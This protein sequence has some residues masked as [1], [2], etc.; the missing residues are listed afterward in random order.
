ME[1]IEARGFTRSLYNYL[2]EDQYGALQAALVRNPETGDVI[3]GT[4]GFR[5]MRWNDAARGKGRRGGLR[6]IYYYFE[7]DRQIWMM[8]IYSKKEAAD[9]SAAE[10]K[11]LRSLIQHEIEQRRHHRE[12]G[13]S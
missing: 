7:A 4:G 1:L 8:S 12:E 13:K 9:L 10:K 2:N 11:T 6:I 5:K 3:P